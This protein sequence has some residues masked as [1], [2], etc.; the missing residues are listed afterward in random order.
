[1]KT[2][3]ATAENYPAPVIALLEAGANPNLQDNSGKSPLHYAAAYGI[4]KI[5]SALLDAGADPA[6]NDKSGKTPWD[7]AKENSALEGTEVYWR[8]NEARFK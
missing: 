2:A 3:M 5:V 4:P 8:L 7:Y 6:A 1:M